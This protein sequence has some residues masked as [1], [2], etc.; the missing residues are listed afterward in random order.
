[1]REGCEKC[2]ARL[3]ALSLKFR[4]SRSRRPESR[5]SLHRL[6]AALQPGRGGGG[7]QRQLAGRCR[8]PGLQQPGDVTVQRLD[9]LL[10]LLESQLRPF[11]VFGDRDQPTGLLGQA[12]ALIGQAVSDLDRALEVIERGFGGLQRRLA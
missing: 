7:I 5:T 2:C 3:S 1:M 8:G 4:A 9:G 12:E 11:D 6:F 10:T